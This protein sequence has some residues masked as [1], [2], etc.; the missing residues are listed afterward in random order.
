MRRAR[1]SPAFSYLCR[2]SSG[3]CM[4]CASSPTDSECRNWVLPDM[5][6]RLE[7]ALHS[8]S[9]E[10]RISRPDSLSRG[11]RAKPEAS[12]TTATTSTGRPRDTRWQPRPSA[13]TCK[14]RRKSAIVTMSNNP[15][16]AKAG[17]SQPEDAPATASPPAI[18][19][20]EGLSPPLGSP[21]GWASS[22]SPSAPCCWYLPCSR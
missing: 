22:L 21:V 19:R 12:L 2:P 17:R 9:P 3:C 5:P 18:R 6:Q 11:R 7:S 8:I 13:T 4:T 14:R 15:S 20:S 1:G 16:T 10:H